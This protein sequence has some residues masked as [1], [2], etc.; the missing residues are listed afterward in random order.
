MSFLFSSASFY[1]NIHA[2]NNIKLN[3]EKTFFSAK[4]IQKI[5]N[6]AIVLCKKA[7]WPKN[8][9]LRNQVA[10]VSS[11]YNQLNDADL[12]KKTHEK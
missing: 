3:S 1:I 6:K 8:E 12:N 7:K 9:V 11:T 10:I 2:R 4:K 5:D